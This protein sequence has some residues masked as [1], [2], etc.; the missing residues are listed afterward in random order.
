MTDLVGQVCKLQKTSPSSS[1]ALGRLLVGTTL[2][3]SQMK[4]GH[5]I[6]FQFHCSGPVKGLYAQSTYEGEIRGYISGREAPMSHRDGQFSLSP[7]VGEGKMTVLTS[8]PGL[9][10]PRQSQVEIFNGEIGEDI[11]HYLHQ[12]MQISCLLSVGVKI[13]SEGK[14]VAAGGVLIE[15][16]PGHSEETL[17]YIEAQ[18]KQ[19]QSISNLI[20][21]DASHDELFKN[22]LGS[23]E[24][25]EIDQQAITYKCS[26]SKERAQ[27]SVGML[28]KSELEDIMSE[29]KALDIDC[30]MCGEA[31]K[32]TIEDV[33]LIY[34]D[35]T[36][37]PTH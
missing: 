25:K 24:L 10:P 21:K 37:N 26:C 11:A 19:A 2:V 8:T 33:N 18:Q 6:A 20:E 3:S 14:V 15:M 17:T 22:H 12:S 27:R 23:L 4:H 29:G 30:E 7:V 13:G 35:I 31:Y 36:K 1:V 9:H 28:G 16:M 34:K 5:S 32:V